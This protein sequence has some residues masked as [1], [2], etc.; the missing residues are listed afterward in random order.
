M[1]MACGLKLHVRDWLWHLTLNT[2]ELKNENKPIAQ[3]HEIFSYAF[4]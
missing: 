3:G 2:G 1:I 4:D